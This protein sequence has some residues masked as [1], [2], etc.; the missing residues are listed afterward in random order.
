MRKKDVGHIS[1][2]CIFLVILGLKSEYC[3]GQSLEYVLQHLVSEIPEMK[4]LRL[5]L[6]NRKLSYENYRKQFLPAISF[7]WN[8][9]QFNHSIQ[10]LQNASDGSYNYIK[11]YTASTGANVALQQSLGVTGGTIRI[12][13]TLDYL[14]EFS[15]GKN[16]YTTRPFYISLSQPLWGGHKEYLFQ[17]EL[18]RMQ[19]E[20]AL[21]HFIEERSELEE[22]TVTLYLNA[23]L[24]HLSLEHAE[25]M[26]LSSDT[27]LNV[28]RLALQHG[29]IT[30]YEFNQIKLECAE[31]EHT[32]IQ[33][34]AAYE[35]ALRE[36][37]SFL[38]IPAPL[39]LLDS[40]PFDFPEIN[41]EEAFQY[42]M[43]NNPEILNQEYTILQA[44]YRNWQT[45]RENRFQGNISVDYGVNR[46]ASSFSSAYRH[47]ENR[48]N[49]SVSLTLPLFDWGIGRNKIR[50]AQNETAMTELDAERSLKNHEQNV[51]KKVSLYNTALSGYALA[52]KSYELSVSNYE[53]MLQ[54]FNISRITV[55]ELLDSRRSVYSFQE[56]YYESLYTL[57]TYY[58][59]LR[60]LC[61]YD[62]KRNCNVGELFK[63]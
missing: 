4:K 21:R 33:T 41:A 58:Y 40:L 19:Y 34:H 53:L 25:L 10:R 8:S 24:T 36:I 52:R 9:F 46:Y 29:R 23:F 13:T 61:L 55:S 62:F 16:N 38:C 31:S 30:D 6:E 35:M 39:I 3:M 56:Q 44:K 60:T 28:S 27:L 1:S 43:K 15:S 63:L 51:F 37:Q 45:K 47:P 22:Q 26:K 12:G 20:L 5:E 50:M 2:I 57:Y 18:A 11:D 14:H 59:Q 54:R 32:V 17:K 7:Q 48:Q 49:I 42:A